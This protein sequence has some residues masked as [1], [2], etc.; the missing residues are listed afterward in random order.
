MKVC[1]IGGGL[2][3]LVAAHTLAGDV[4]IDLF[5]EQPFLGGCLSSYTIG[6]FSIERYYHHCFS[7]DTSLL[8]LL[9]NMGLM[10]RLEWRNASTGYFAG[11]RVYPLTTP[12]EILKYPFLSLTDKA[13]L[14][15]LTL[16][17]RSLSTAELDTVPA[18]E[19]IRKTLGDR[20]YTSFFE[21]LLNAKFGENKGE[22]SAA[23]LVSR[24]AIRSDRGAGGERLGYL[25]GGFSQLIDALAGSIQKKGGGIHTRTPVVST[26]RAGSSWEVNGTPYDAVISTVPPQELE[27]IGGPA[28]VAI[29]YQGAACVTL[30]LSREATG[31]IYWLNMKDPAPYGAVVAHTNFIPYT[32]YGCNIVYLASYFTGSLPQDTESRMI[33]D[34]CRRFSVQK[35]EILWNRMAVDHFAGPVYTLGYRAKIPAYEHG[36]LFMAGMFSGPNYPERSMDGAVRAGLEVA[37]LVRRTVLHG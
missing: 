5:E 31:G 1:I 17:A 16:R 24:I 10:G 7:R 22:V 6:D 9:E 37:G 19:Y 14:G 32:R 21:P 3:G 25:N 26:R 4:A 15:L 11:G 33:A 18:E 36:G 30:G 35:D 23:W 29:R 13:R 12:V 34:F 2:T 20:I 8:S 27:R 28:T